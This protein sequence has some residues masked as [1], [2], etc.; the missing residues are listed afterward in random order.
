MGR[1][2]ADEVVAGEEAFHGPQVVHDGE[3][4]LVAAHQEIRGVGEGRE[5]GQGAEVGHHHVTHDEPSPRHPGRHRRRFAARPQEDEEGDEHQQELAAGDRV[6]AHRERERLADRG[7]NARR[8]REAEAG[9]QHGAQH[10][11]AVHGEGGDQIEEQEEDVDP[12]QLL[13]EA[14]GQPVQAG[15]Q[16]R[17]TAGGGEPGIQRH[18]DDQRDER[19]GERDQQ[20]L[21]RL[22]RHALEPRHAPDGEQDDVG[23]AH[24]ET[25]RHRNVPEL[26]EQHAAEDAQQHEG[27]RGAALQPEEAEQEQE[28]D[29]DLHVGTGNPEE[30]QRP[31]HGTSLEQGECNAGPG[32]PG[33]ACAPAPAGSAERAQTEHRGERPPRLR[34]PGRL[35]NLLQRG[36][37]VG[38]GHGRH[39]PLEDELRLHRRELE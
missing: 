29:V 35:R 27:G 36:H 22:V 32:D 21:P 14:A 24:A 26:V 28:G 17:G 37:G 19:P 9:R 1:E 16:R 8:P 12:V 3:L 15:H 5:D 25:A 20:L 13:E 34:E 11:A 31:G 7:G 6:K 23:R 30:A 4:A 39:R 18:G 33:P 2:A 10:A 38:G